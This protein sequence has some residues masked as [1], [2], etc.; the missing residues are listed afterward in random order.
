MSALDTIEP[1]HRI[2]GIHHD[3]SEAAERAQ[4]TVRRISEQ[5]RR[6]LD[7]QVWLEN[8]RVL[9]LVRAVE[10]VALELRDNP[11]NFGLEVD[12]PGIEIALQFE[13]PLYQPPVAVAVESRIAEATEEVDAELLF[14]QTFIDQA[15]LAEVIRTVLPENSSALLADVV[16]MHPIE[17]G[18]AE[19]V[20]YL[21]LNDED[22]A[23]EMDDTDETFLEYSDPA[24]V[25]ATKRAR[26]PKVTVRRR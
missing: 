4:R 17:Q 18:A 20:G 21:A 1:D 19:I 7:D 26:L 10:G 24:D 13:R 12:L 5:L 25:D 16:A 2:R 3:W 22:M 15:R 9:D 23:V 14:A 6:F 11:R 8:R